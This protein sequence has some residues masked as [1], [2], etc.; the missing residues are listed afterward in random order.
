MSFFETFF[1]KYNYMLKGQ[2]PLHIKIAIGELFACTAFNCKGDFDIFKSI[3]T[4]TYGVMV[5]L[6]LISATKELLIF[7]KE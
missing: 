2:T 5:E 3:A 7:G 1:I 4:K 6:L